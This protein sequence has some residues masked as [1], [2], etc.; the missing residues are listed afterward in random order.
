MARR[1]WKPD[2]FDSPWK[3]ALQRYLQQFLAF[4]FP[5]IA[6]DIDWAR[7]YDGLDKEFQQIIRRAKVGKGI[8][9]K[10]FKV[11]LRDGREHWLLIHIEVQGYYEEAFPERM[12]RYNVA[13]YALYNRE[14]VSIAVLCDADPNWRPTS[15][16][17]GAGA[18]K[19]GSTSWLPSC[20]TTSGTCTL[21]RRARTLLPRS[22]SRTVRR[23]PRAAIR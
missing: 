10:L 22:S 3:A 11:W 13:A 4:F 5:A 15:I 12:F 7:G 6:A 21:W 14:V 9:D 1:T 17:T 23:W 18:V 20:W 8:A 16:P 19:R 2:D